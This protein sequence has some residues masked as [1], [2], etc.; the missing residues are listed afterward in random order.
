MVREIQTPNLWRKAAGCGLAAAAAA[1]VAACGSAGG[2]AASPASGQTGAQPGAGTAGVVAA[3]QLSGVGTVLVDRSGRTIYSPEQ[4]ASGT[5]RCT[6]GCLSFWFPVTVSSAPVPSHAS[7]LAGVLGTVHRPDDGKT[8]LTYNGKPLYTFRLDQSPGQV[9]GNDFTDHF[10]G[11][12]FTW[13]AVTASG[14]PGGSGQT[15][16]S[17]SAGPSG[18]SGYGY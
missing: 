11:T 15:G 3:H 8:Q 13:Q 2:N 5:I 1:L 4:E 16:T 14:T 17:P 6:G 10:G 18:G 7:G 9:H 12:S